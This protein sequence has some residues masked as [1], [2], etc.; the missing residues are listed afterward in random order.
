M[1]EFIAVKREPEEIPRRGVIGPEDYVGNDVEAVAS[2][3]A[4][5]SLQEEEELR[6]YDEEIQQLIFKQGVATN[7]AA[8][9]KDDEWRRVCEEDWLMTELLHRVGHAAASSSILVAAAS[10]K[11]HPSSSRS[12]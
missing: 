5:R 1:G 9:E 4:A 12:M 7:L 2:A 6:R 11:I 3:I 10:P 8:K